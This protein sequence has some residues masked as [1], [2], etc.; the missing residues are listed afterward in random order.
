[1]KLSELLPNFSELRTHAANDSS[2]HP[3]I[4][5]IE[6]KKSI[7]PLNNRKFSPVTFKEFIEKTI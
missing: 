5:A 6:A 2:S 3:H 7:F 4:D 1:M